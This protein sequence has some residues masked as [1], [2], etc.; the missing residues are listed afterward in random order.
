MKTNRQ[1][2]PR[3]SWLLISIL[4]GTLLGVSAQPRSSQYSV[5]KELTRGCDSGSRRGANP[6][7]FSR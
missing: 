4:P 5:V 1:F 7:C 3:D 2:L 6:T